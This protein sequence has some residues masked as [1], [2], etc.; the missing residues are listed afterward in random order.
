[1]LLVGENSLMAIFGY[2]SEKPRSRAKR[3]PKSFM[4][5]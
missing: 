5:T 3:L 2:Q 1:M 4:I